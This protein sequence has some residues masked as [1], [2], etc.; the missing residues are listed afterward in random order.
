MILDEDF[1]MLEGLSKS[2]HVVFVARED[3][4]FGGDCQVKGLSKAGFTVVF[5]G[6]F[7]TFFFPFRY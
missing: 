1:A 2:E 7:K 5:D 4:P 6:G 3:I